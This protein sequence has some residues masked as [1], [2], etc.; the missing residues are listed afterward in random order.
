VTS[1]FSI[2]EAKRERCSRHVGA[3]R[4][5]R[6]SHASALIVEDFVAP[7]ARHDLRDQDA[8]GRPQEIRSCGGMYIPV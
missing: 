5:G 8:D 2:V 1:K 6:R 3:V 7:L 4:Q